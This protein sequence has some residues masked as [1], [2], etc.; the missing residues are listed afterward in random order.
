MADS[1]T[2][3]CGDLQLYAGRFGSQQDVGQDSRVVLDLSR[4]I[5]NSGRNI[6]TDN[7]LPATLWHK[8]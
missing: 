3:Y 2:F 4:S 7:F 6:T 5:A 1:E 8:N